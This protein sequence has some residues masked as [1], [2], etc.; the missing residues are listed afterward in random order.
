M[1]AV[2]MEFGL[3]ALLFTGFAAVLSPLTALGHHALAGRVRAFLRVCHR[4]PPGFTVSLTILSRKLL[5]MGTT[6]EFE[7]C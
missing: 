1:V 3:I 4:E 6:A 7:S 5:V 2:A